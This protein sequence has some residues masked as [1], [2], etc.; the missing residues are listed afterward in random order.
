MATKAQE[1]ARKRNEAQWRLKGV[2]SNLTDIKN[3][4]PLIALESMEIE[5]ALA[6]INSVIKNW[7]SR[8]SY[9]KRVYLA[10]DKK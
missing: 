8:N 6:L 3:N 1:W 4:L 2:I 9:S 7:G 10:R 5:E